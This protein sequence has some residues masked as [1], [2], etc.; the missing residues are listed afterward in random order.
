MTNEPSTARE[1]AVKRLTARR[2]FWMHLATY[3]IFN[4]AMVFIWYVTGRSYFWPGWILGLWGAG[5]LVHAWD[6]WLRRP[7]TEDDIRREIGRQ[8]GSHA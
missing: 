2:D 6:V 5:L 7:I 4:G 8:S 3:A 1:A